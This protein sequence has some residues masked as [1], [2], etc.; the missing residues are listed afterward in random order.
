MQHF[1]QCQI[2]YQYLNEFTFWKS[3]AFAYFWSCFPISDQFSL[4]ARSSQGSYSEES[5]CPEMSRKMHNVYFKNCI[6]DSKTQW[7]NICFSIIPDIYFSLCYGYLH[8]G[9]QAVGNISVWDSVSIVTNKLNI[10]SNPCCRSQS[11]FLEVMFKFHWSNFLYTPEVKG[12]QICKA[13]PGRNVQPRGLE[14]SAKSN[15]IYHQNSCMFVKK[16]SCET[17]IDTIKK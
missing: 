13:A 3:V 9:I 10:L 12:V 5:Q 17:V 1:C 16:F 8:F 11:S 7:I 14:N 15:I 6:F 2:Y 4:A